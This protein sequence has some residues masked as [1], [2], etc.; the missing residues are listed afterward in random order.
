MPT[1]VSEKRIVDSWNVS[2][3]SHQAMEVPVPAVAL[4]KL[5]RCKGHETEMKSISVAEAATC[6]ESTVRGLGVMTVVDVFH[7]SIVSWV[8][9]HPEH[10]IRASHESGSS[11]I[12]PN[13]VV[14]SD[15]RGD[16]GHDRPASYH[17]FDGRPDMSLP[18]RQST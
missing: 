15:R 12:R 9:S 14:L 17:G 5:S 8:Q 7:L 6:A 16:S 1:R 4:L 10:S 3:L 2:T 18:T 13:M 11:T